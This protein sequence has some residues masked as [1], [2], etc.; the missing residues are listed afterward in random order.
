M[1]LDSWEIGEH[2]DIFAYIHPEEWTWIIEN[3]FHM[4]PG[5]NGGFLSHGGTPQSSSIDGFSMIQKP[6]SDK[7]VPPFTEP[8][9]IT[10]PVIHVDM[11]IHFEL[12]I[13]FHHVLKL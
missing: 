13:D 4:I 11:V 6:S 8:P 3:H 2:G 10:D 9:H 5:V 7:G 1:P 12:I